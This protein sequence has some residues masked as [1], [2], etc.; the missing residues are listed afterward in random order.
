MTNRA[1]E[2]IRGAYSIPNVGGQKSQR[3]GEKK[4]RRINPS[5]A[6]KDSWKVLTLVS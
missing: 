4:E 6:D 5:N 3:R 1:R 2:N